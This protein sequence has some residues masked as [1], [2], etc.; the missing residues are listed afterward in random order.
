VVVKVHDPETDPALLAV[1]IRIAALPELRGVFLPPE[2]VPERIRVHLGDRVAGRVLSAWPA[3]VPLSP[4]ELDEAPWEIG[5][6]LLARLH[7]VPVAAL[8]PALVPGCPPP[9][10]GAPD[11]VRRSLDR[12]H[13]VAP[14][15][16]ETALVTEAYRSLP[17]WAVG[18]AADPG[19][20]TT[21][22][23]GD[24]HLGQLVR[25]DGRWHLID[26][27]DLG[28]GNP[29]W[30]L[31][32][33]AAWF[34]TGVLDPAVWARFLD[35]YLAAGGPAVPDPTDHWATL[36]VPARAMVVQT[37]AVALAHAQ[38]HAEDLDD[39]AMAFLDGCRRIRSA[40]R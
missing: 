15:L 28:L 27:D 38:E 19:Q 18:A 20:V 6:R 21:P 17:R 11:R 39:V 12:L 35:S 24:W 2:P 5:G 32:R 30:D 3:G 9:P 25:R 22:A 16:P 36:D 23:H 1:R 33:P 34:A 8:G 31:A 4:T 29:A 40:S 14:E 10:A 7:T 13:R 26:V 37:A